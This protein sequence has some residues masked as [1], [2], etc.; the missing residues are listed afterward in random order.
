LITFCSSTVASQA[1]RG[2]QFGKEDGVGET[3]G[4]CAERSRH[5]PND[6]KAQARQAF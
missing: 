5:K 2:R 3:F 6:Q 1:K 4:E